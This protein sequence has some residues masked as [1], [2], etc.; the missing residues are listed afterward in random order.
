M[1]KK[2]TEASEAEGIKETRPE[3]EVREGMAGR[4]RSRARVRSCVTERWGREKRRMKRRW[5]EK[6]ESLQ[7]GGVQRWLEGWWCGGIG[8]REEGMED[9]R[10]GEGKEASESSFWQRVVVNAMSNLMVILKTNIFACIGRK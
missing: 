4:L 10:L 2:V 7:W 1:E 3:V 8:S 6:G 9:R 5:R